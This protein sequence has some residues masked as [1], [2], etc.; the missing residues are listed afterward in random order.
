ME[1]NKK[2]KWYVT[3]SPVIWKEIHHWGGKR[4]LIGGL[5]EFW[6]YIYCYYGLESIIPKTELRKLA[7]DNLRVTL[8]KYSG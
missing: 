6:E 5:G 1:I 2:A 7:A 4:Y 3:N 8:M